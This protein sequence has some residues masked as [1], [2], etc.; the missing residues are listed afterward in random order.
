VK[1]EVFYI[2]DCP[3]HQPVVDRVREVLRS[4]AMSERI[5]EVEV[6]T[7]AEAE[8]LR[9]IGSPTVRVNGLDV[10]PEAR[11]VHHFGMGC[12]SYLDN[13]RRSGLPSVDLI[14]RSLPD[15]QKN[16]LEQGAA[17]SHDEQAPVPQKG[18][19]SRVL[20][21]GGIAAILASTCCLGPLILVTLGFSGAWIGNLALLEP[22]RPWFIAAAL[23][24]LFFAGRRIFR[25][26]EACAPGEV[27]ALPTSRRAFKALFGV[28]AALVVVAFAF[29]YV[30]RFFY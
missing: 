10:E 3:N 1:F 19:E 15:M 29:P 4:A 14:R 2:A 7:S 11:A 20:V 8:A 22:Y 18:A 17:L 6:C 25:R 24:A 9:F 13:G 12:R 16:S 5:E 21:A 30:A 26:V 28:V 27:C 23:V